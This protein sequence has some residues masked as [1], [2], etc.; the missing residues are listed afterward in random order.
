MKNIA[1]FVNYSSDKKVSNRTKY[2]LENIRELYDYVVI[3][4]NSKLTKKNAKILESYCDK[5]IVRTNVGFDFAAWRDGMKAIGWGKLANYET[6]TL[7]NDTC[8]FPL[9][10]IDKIIKN[11]NDNKSIDFWGASIHGKTRTG[12]PGSNGPVPEHI[13][14]YFMVFKNN[15][16]KSIAFQTFWD[17]VDDLAK[18]NEVISKYETGL[19]SY[20]SKAGFR[21]DA[22]YNPDKYNDE[23]IIDAVYQI[24]QLLIRKHFPF[25]KL[26]AVNPSNLD[27]IIKEIIINN[28][29]YP[30][31]YIKSYSPISTSRTRRTVSSV[32]KKIRSKVI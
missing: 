6:V 17:E 15:V 20:L 30:I 2:A 22:I 1:F 21:Y 29:A 8:I 5:L 28:S 25:I 18:V 19:T 10:P 16:V 3:I 27:I 31:D 23:G 14:S 26:K 24:P 13:Q 11:F 12:M 7:V 32:I 4:S 9:F